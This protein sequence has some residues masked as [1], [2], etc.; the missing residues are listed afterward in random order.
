MKK[1]DSTYIIVLIG[2]MIDQFIKFLIRKNL[3][4][5]TSIPLIPH[6]F[7]LT[8]I[9]NKGAAWGIFSNNT[10]ILI[11]ISFISFFLILKYIK[12]ES[13]WNSSKTIAF[14]LILSGLIGNLIDRLFYHSVTDYLDF[15]ILGYHYPVF[16]LA[17]ILIV[18]G[19]LLII[20]ELVRSE[21]DEHRSIKSKRRN[22]KN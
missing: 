3:K 19:A 9:E 18:V 1:K 7:H 8:H 13:T 6:F 11:L 15:T 21:I 5:L 12:E 14:G 22:R 10:P 2:L 4:L 20:L 16:N 17:D